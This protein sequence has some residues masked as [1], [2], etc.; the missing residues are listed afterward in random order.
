LPH[1]VSGASFFPI[2]AFKAA[3]FGDEHRSGFTGLENF[4]DCSFIENGNRH[5]S[6]AKRLQKNLERQRAN[7]ERQ[8]KERLAERL[9]ELGEDPQQ[10]L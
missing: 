9:R 8:Q 1:I 10:F 5:L 2:P 7:D 4:Q 3:N 6:E